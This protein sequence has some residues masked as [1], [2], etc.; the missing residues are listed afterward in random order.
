MDKSAGGL[1]RRIRMIVI[2]GISIMLLSFGIAGYFIVKKNIEE[3]INKRLA[4][5]RLLRNNIDN[6]L[7]DNIN[8]LY[9]ISLSGA[10]DLHDGTLEPEREALKAAYRYSLFGDGVFLLDRVGNIV[11]DYP[12][13]IR[14]TPLNVLS[15]EPVR[16][17][18]AEGR[19][20]VSNVYAGDMG[21]KNLYVLAPLKDR[22]G[23]VVG[24][25]GGQIDP[26]NPTL[27]QKFGLSDIG[28]HMYVDI[29]DS[30]GMI[31]SS[32]DPGRIL[33][34]CNRD[35]FFTKV[36]AA[37]MERVADCHICHFQDKTADKHKTILAFVPLETAPW[38]IAIQEPRE[39]IFAPAAALQNTFAALGVVFI[40]TA[41]ILTIGMNRGIVDP[42]KALIRGADRIARGDLSRP[43]AP[44]GSD[45]IGWLSHSFE[46]MRRRLLASLEDIRRHNAELEHRVQ[47]RTRELEQGRQTAEKLLKKIITSEEDERK[48]VSRELHDTTLQD[49]SAVIMHIDMCKLHPD[50]ITTE[51]IDAI[52]RIVL[53]SWEGVISTIQNLRPSLLDDLGL[54]SAIKSL[55]DIHLGERGIN[56]FMNADGLA[57]MRFRPEVEITL[58]RIAQESITNIARHARADNVFVLFKLAGNTVILDIEDD[59]VGFDMDGIFNPP[60]PD[61]KMSRGLGLLGMR[62]RVNLING[63]LEVCSLQ[64]LGTQINVRLPLEP[65]EVR[66]A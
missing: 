59:G 7:K 25:I 40:G 63:Q 12:E 36:I 53:N 26:T 46:T 41:L 2:A 57:E 45:E 52:R 19:P 28:R 11:L 13:R 15:I 14:D 60:A 6:I 51:K 65:A 66:H 29:V 48:R 24:A 21:R 54:S 31:I 50:E 3:S 38:G 43:V 58:F 4:L 20:V 37:K 30:N 32:S 22:N 42:L 5:S 61:V 44:Q 39:E 35:K 64:G 56:Y 18:L 17:M 55:L 27:A 62:E 8:R 33:T 47:E 9:D 16:R 23:A 49:L 34:Q 10:V 1:R